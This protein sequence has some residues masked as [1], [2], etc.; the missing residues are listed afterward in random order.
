MVRRM[1]FGR[2]V[3][4][5]AVDT[6]VQKQLGSTTDWRGTPLLYLAPGDVTKGRIEPIYW[7]QTCR[8]FSQQKLRVHLIALRVAAPDAVDPADVW[9][10]FG[11][12][13]SFR[14]SRV[15]T[16][17]RTDSST[18][19]FQASASAVSAAVAARL[20]LRSRHGRGIVYTK[21]PALLGALARARPLLPRGI[22]LVLELHALPS[23]RARRATRSADLLL[24]SSSKL[25]HDLHVLFEI[26]PERIQVEPPLAPITDPTVSRSDARARLGLPAHAVIGCYSGK[27]LEAQIE[28]LL[29][30]TVHLLQLLPGF[31]LMLVGGNPRARAAIRDR[32]RALGISGAVDVV[33]FVPPASVRLYQAAA[34]V[35]LLHLM[36]ST[37]AWEYAMP[38]K[39][40]DYMAA[41]RP[42]V[43]TAFPL[44][45]EVFGVG[46]ARAVTVEDHDPR[47]FATAVLDVVND[48]TASEAMAQRAATWVAARTWGDRAARVLT[49]LGPTGGRGHHS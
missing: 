44:S 29:Q 22:S 40:F 39:A 17:L 12:E 37:P 41:G 36:R 15:P 16:P 46:H 23:L 13:Q 7:M 4:T 31:K 27:L 9:A 48:P 3:R 1:V 18:L 49:T 5:H 24:A 33:G 6:A 42:I 35:L 20:A 2:G 25:A 47:A 45:G 26:E 10:H 14:V 38:A 43:S 8:A 30:A 11:F 28:F 19:A 34:D 21:S 32:T